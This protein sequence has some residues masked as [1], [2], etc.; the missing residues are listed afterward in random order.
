[1]PPVNETR[2]KTEMKSLLAEGLR[3]AG[4]TAG[5]VLL[6]D[7]ERANLPAVTAGLKAGEK[8]G[9]FFGT[10][11]DKGLWKK[12]SARTVR[13]DPRFNLHPLVV[14]LRRGRRESGL[15]VLLKKRRPFS[16][17]ER[18]AAAAAGRAAE[19][20]VNLFNDLAQI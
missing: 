6:R 12:L 1:M 10:D 19:R 3:A 13:T 18:K 20:L 16:P 5:G 9:L 17:A 11:D 2:W 7:N 4:C 8:I 15:L 14:P